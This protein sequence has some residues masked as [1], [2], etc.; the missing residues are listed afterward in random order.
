V[1]RT[2]YDLFALWV[3]LV[4]WQRLALAF[5]ENAKEAQRTKPEKNLNTQV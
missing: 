4:I 2:A 3:K 5:A 1:A